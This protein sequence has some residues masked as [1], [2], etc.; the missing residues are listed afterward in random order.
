MTEAQGW[1]FLGLLAFF[2]LVYVLRQP[3]DVQRKLIKAI[4][5]IAVAPVALFVLF[6]LVVGILFFGFGIEIM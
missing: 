4:I 5:F 6:F 3:T 2:M 1:V